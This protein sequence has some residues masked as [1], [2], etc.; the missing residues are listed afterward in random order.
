MKNGLDIF[1]SLN[2]PYTI[3][4]QTILIMYL[5][6]TVFIQPFSPTSQYFRYCR[7]SDSP[8]INLLRPDTPVFSKNPDMIDSFDIIDSPITQQSWYFRQS[9]LT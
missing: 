6:S 3:G 2:I 8:N 4:L 5:F 1:D 7:F 9:R